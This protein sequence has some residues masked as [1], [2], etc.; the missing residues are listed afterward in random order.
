MADT[1]RTRAYLLGTSFPDNTVGSISAQDM[2]D[3]VVTAMGSYANIN[4]N[5]GDGSPTA[6][7]VA[8]STT[9]TLD[10]SAGSSGANGPDDTDGSSYGADAD[11]ANDRI[12]VYTKGIFSVCANISYA[13]GT[14]SNN[15]WKWVVATQ[16]DGGS[17]V[18]SNFKVIRLVTSATDYAS[19]SLQGILDLTG[20]TNYTDVL[21]RVRHNKGS[22]EDLYLNYG[23]MNVE[24]IG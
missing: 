9:V 10:W 18:E 1:R 14:A 16:A 12:R 19:I 4:N 2:R 17:V 21:M 8:T 6:Q 5:A 7:A 20:H 24:R 23:M 11:Y 13:Q 22:S 3:Y 15:Q